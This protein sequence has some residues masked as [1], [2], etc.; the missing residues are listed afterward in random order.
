MAGRGFP[1]LWLINK[2]RTNFATAVYFCMKTISASWTIHFPHPPHPRRFPWYL[3]QVN[4]YIVL[5][6]WFIKFLILWQAD[7]CFECGYF[8]V[9][10]SSNILVWNFVILNILSSPPVWIF[11]Q[12]DCCSALCIKF[13]HVRMPDHKKFKQNTQK[14]I[15]IGGNSFHLSL[16]SPKA[17][18][19]SPIGFCKT[20]NSSSS[21]ERTDWKDEVLMKY[22]SPMLNQQT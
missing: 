13:K 17:L 5:A 6:E 21:S 10:S 7:S 14:L 4:R 2:R 3:Y 9:F 20:T 19:M 12:A 15:M 1:S 22:V 16:I 8:E 11:W 18:L